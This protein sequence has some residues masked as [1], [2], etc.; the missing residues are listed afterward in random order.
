MGTFSILEFLMFVFVFLILPVVL[1][2][3]EHR[4]AKRLGYTGRRAYLRAVPYTDAQRKDAADSA[5]QG[6]IICALGT[7][8]PLLLI[9]GIFP[10]FYGGR[11]VLYATLGLGLVDDADAYDR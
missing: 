9:V 6:I 3:S 11:K 8:F 5:L 2:I 7:Y 1:F 4:K 10:L